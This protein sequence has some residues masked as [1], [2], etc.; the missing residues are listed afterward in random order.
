MAPQIQLS[1]VD[2]HALYATM[3]SVS[4]TRTSF[5][6]MLYSSSFFH[7]MFFALVCKVF[8]RIILNK[9]LHYFIGESPNTMIIISY[10]LCIYN[11]NCYDQGHHTSFKLATFLFL[12]SIST[13]TFVLA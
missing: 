4:H 8:L 2:G 10:K 11:Y 12:L 13:I 7:K 6:D 3:T 5:S 9:P 1:L